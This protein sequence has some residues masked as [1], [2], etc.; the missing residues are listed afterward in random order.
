M[1]VVFCNTPTH[2]KSSKF[3]AEYFGPLYLLNSE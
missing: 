2:F 3:E 1:S